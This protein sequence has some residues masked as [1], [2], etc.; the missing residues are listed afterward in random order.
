MGLIRLFLY[1]EVMPMR[2]FLIELFALNVAIAV[3]AA[4]GTVKI[5]NLSLSG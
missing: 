5:L 4:Y 3:G 2:Q 1:D